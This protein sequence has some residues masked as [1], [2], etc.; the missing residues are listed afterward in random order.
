MR[1]LLFWGLLPFVIPQA[2]LLR[3]NAPRFA[4][5]TGPKSGVVGNGKTYRFLAIGD[6]VISGVG[7]KNMANAFAGQTA[8]HL[9]SLLNGQIH[10]SARG[11]IGA[12]AK[13]VLN[14]LVPELDAIEQDFILVSVGVNDVTSL[15]RISQWKDNLERL[16]KSLNQHSPNAIIAIAGVPPLEIFP[17]LPKLLRR[18]FGMRA[19]CF[20]DAAHDVVNTFNKVVYLQLDFEDG[21]GKFALDGFHPSEASYNELGKG[22]AEVFARKAID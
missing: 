3:R 19:R 8:T 2:L 16:I 21:P 20:S 11:I 7:A 15:S 9:A 22:A 6:S 12:D 13:A 1:S 4:G 10:W 5:A 17:L 18:L 14:E